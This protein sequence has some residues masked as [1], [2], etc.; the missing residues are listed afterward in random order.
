MVIALLLSLGAIVS[1]AQQP[2]ISA[3]AKD[4]EQPV[5]HAGAD[6]VTFPVAIHTS[7]AK[8][9]YYAR[10]NRISGVCIVELTVDAQG[11]PQ[12]V[13]VIKSLDPG[14]DENAIKSVR[15][16]RFKPAVYKDKPVPVLVNIEVNFR[17]Y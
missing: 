4:T 14:L 7:E 11:K 1:G 16:Y 3:D 6:G 5:A 10:E 2:V 8:F 12:N 9:T 17:L 15:K 13:H